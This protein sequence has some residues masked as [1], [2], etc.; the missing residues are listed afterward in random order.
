MSHIRSS[1]YLPKEHSYPSLLFVIR[2]TYGGTL[3]HLTFQ[4]VALRH[5]SIPRPLTLHHTKVRPLLY[6]LENHLVFVRVIVIQSTHK[7]MENCSTEC[8]GGKK[9]N[10][11]NSYIAYS[12]DVQAFSAL[13]HAFKKFARVCVLQ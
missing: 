1:T 6:T 5:I 3:G 10:S 4:D 9:N 12:R 13:G 11:Q 8:L 2:C 7:I